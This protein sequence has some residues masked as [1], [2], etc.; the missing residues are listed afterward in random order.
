MFAKKIK[1]QL[2]LI[3]L[4][5][6][7]LVIVFLASFTFYQSKIS[8]E[9]GL[10]ER[11]NLITA[12]AALMSEFYLYTGNVPKLEEIADLLQKVDGLVF[13]RFIDNSGS[14]LVERRNTQAGTNFEPYYLVVKSS[15]IQLDDFD[16]IEPAA[17]KSEPL[18]SVMIGLSRD[19]IS[20]QQQQ[21][22]YL[23]LFVSLLSLLIGIILITIFSR[24]FNTAVNSLLDVAYKIQQGD[25][26][27]RCVENG[28]GEWL[29]FQRSFNKMIDALQRNE[30]ELNTKINQAT[31]SLNN[32]VKQLADKNSE[33]ENTRKE[34]VNLESAKA[35]TEERTRI[36]KDM[37]DGIGSQLVETI[38]LVELEPDTEIT[39]NIKTILTDC[40]D[41]FRL[42]IDSLN[43]QKKSLNTLLAENNIRLRWRVSDVSDRILLEPQQSLHLL[44]IFQ[45]AFTNIMKH[46]DASVVTFTASTQNDAI[47]VEIKD[48]G[49][50]VDQ[51]SLN[52]ER[53]ISTM[54]WRANELGGEL[55]LFQDNSTGFIV[56]L[57]IPS[58]DN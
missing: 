44:R 53:G 1:T 34:T 25:Y 4:A 36:M 32:T 26:K 30:Q 21:G 10:N 49:R 39:R 9:K 5:P 50:S 58:I 38:A 33:L 15:N 51:Q 37:H 22:H 24:K 47:K 27:V 13:I 12:Q 56:T 20:S 7:L 3:A 55:M 19:S 42:I 6:L 16:D 57:V 28:S 2:K 23:V 40:L 35:I 54:K 31:Q 48:N 18:G 41:D 11:G 8:L 52:L 43:V 29:T 14:T 45:E 17:N 46:S